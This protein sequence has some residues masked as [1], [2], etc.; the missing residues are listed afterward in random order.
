MRFDH[1]HT[2]AQLLAAA[3]SI[4]PDDGFVASSYG[5]ALHRA[6][7]V[8]EAL[9]T[10]QGIAPAGPED[11]HANYGQGACHAAL[12]HRQPALECFRTAFDRYRLD[13]VEDC[14]LSAW[15]ELKASRNDLLK[16]TQDF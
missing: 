13:S 3:C 15:Q 6:G 9:R 4:D 12:G 16:E 10:Y 5:D 8:R 1:A 2:A 14:L 11:F 7:L